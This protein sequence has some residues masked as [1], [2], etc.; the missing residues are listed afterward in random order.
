[1][2]DSKNVASANNA[3]DPASDS[4]LITYGNKSVELRAMKDAISVYQNSFAEKE[5]ILEAEQRKLEELN[6]QAWSLEDSLCEQVWQFSHEH[7]FCAIFQ[8]HPFVMNRARLRS[9]CKDDEENNCELIDLMCE[10]EAIEAEIIDLS[11]R[12]N[13]KQKVESALTKLRRLQLISD[14]IT[15]LLRLIRP[16]ESVCKLEISMPVYD[17][18]SSNDENKVKRKN[19]PG[20]TKQMKIDKSHF[21]PKK[22]VMFTTPK[23]YPQLSLER[24]IVFS[25]NT[26]TSNETLKNF[27]LKKRS[28]ISIRFQE[29]REHK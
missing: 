7:D 29:Y 9:N 28:E 1:M 16:S 24:S 3:R 23:N 17:E 19:D 15:E 4:P 14:D 21:V 11:Q 12:T 5:K 26:L 27:T 10:I 22:K 2:I 20:D 25:A 18:I 13:V 6:Y 8:Y